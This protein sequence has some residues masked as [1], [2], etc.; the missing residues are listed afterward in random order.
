MSV[1]TGV[2]L[3]VAIGIQSPIALQLA[4]DFWR[5][6]SQTKI[7]RSNAVWR[8]IWI[9]DQCLH[10]ILFDRHVADKCNLRYVLRYFKV[11]L[12][13]Q[14]PGQ[15]ICKRHLRTEQQKTVIPF[16]LSIVACAYAQAS[17]IAKFAQASFQLSEEIKHWWT[18][19]VGSNG[20]TPILIID[21][22]LSILGTQG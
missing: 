3:H 7:M 12:H 14:V 8:N 20:I 17:H 2:F 19:R 1:L 6:I 10:R 15:R 5:G 13:L 16:C 21:I 22:F 4:H 18:H 11:V 9:T